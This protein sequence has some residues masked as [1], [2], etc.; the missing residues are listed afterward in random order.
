[1]CGKFENLPHTP[2]IWFMAVAILLIPPSHMPSL[3][4]SR[5]AHLDLAVTDAPLRQ[6]QK[7]PAQIDLI[8]DD[9]D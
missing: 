6:G 3:T 8:P 9:Q 5:S 2:A 7:P 4:A 1:M